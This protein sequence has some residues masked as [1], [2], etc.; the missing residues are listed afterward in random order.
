MFVYYGV[1]VFLG[2]IQMGLKGQGARLWVQIEML[3]IGVLAI[4]FVQMINDLVVVGSL[5][6]I[7]GSNV[8]DHRV[9][10]G[11]LIERLKT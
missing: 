9:V 1:N 7:S 10:T 6:G 5:V 11:W 2:S 8:S 4:S 3:P